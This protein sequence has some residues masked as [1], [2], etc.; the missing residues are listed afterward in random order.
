M[1]VGDLVRL[2]PSRL[3]KEVAYAWPSTTG[4]VIDMI[5]DDDGFYDCLVQLPHG[6]EWF[7]DIQLEVISESRG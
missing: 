5:E 3:V 1:K 7:R 6:K 4:L 2:R